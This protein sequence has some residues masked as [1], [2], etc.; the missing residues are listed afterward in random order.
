FGAAELNASGSLVS[1]F[2]SGGTVVPSFKGKWRPY[3]PSDATLYP[4]GSPGDEKI[5]EAGW[6]VNS[7]STQPGAFALVR[8]NANGSLATSFGSGGLVPTSFPQ[9]SAGAVGV[10][11][12][13]NGSSLPK[14]LAVGEAGGHSGFAFARYNPN[15]SLDTTFGSSGTLYIPFSED[16]EA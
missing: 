6:A 7:S 11:L 12:V 10:V 8:Y 4:T 3:S 14:I 2:G 1:S 9:G 16:A 13:P 15:G 5:L